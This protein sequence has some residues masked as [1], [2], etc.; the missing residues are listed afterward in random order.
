M[1]ASPQKIVIIPARLASS[2]LPN[3]VILDLGGK[4]IV[5]RVYEQAK[6]AKTIDDV[7][8]ATDSD[9]IAGICKK[10][11]DNIIMTRPDH[12]TGTDRIAE[13]IG[14]LSAEIVINVQGD[15]PFIDPD[16]IDELGNR[17]ERFGVPM[18]TVASQLKWVEDLLNPNIVKVT[19]DSHKNALY[20]SRAAIPFA[21]EVN[22]REFVKIP[23][24][25]IYY[26]HFG[27]YAYQK[28]FLMGYAAMTPTAL[29]KT[30]R[31]EQ[32]R[33][34]ENGYTISVVITDR[35]SIG[36]DTEEDLQKAR[37]IAADFF[38]S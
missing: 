30:E 36:I 11:T 21:R 26:R 37:K 28:H 15:E 25:M 23:E 10:F 32:L 17:I 35:Q 3:K 4:P 20:F 19:I 29:E 2:R 6:K 7:Y 16:V 18:A 33:A 5:Q 22:W 34:L 14:K 24:D 8:I 12:P 27:I 1:Q 9:Q 31:L 38:I 13:A